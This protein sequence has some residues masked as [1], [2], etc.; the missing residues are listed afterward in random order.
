MEIFPVITDVSPSVGSAAGGTVVT[1]K[2]M[3]FDAV[4]MLDNVITVDSLPCTV[5]SVKATEIKCESA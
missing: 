3:G 2:G 5:T 4:K 1:V